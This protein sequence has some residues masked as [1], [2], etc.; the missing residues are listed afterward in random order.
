MPDLIRE[1]DYII[2]GA[3]SAG[4]VLANRLSA[5]P[6]NRVLVVEAGGPDRDPLIHIPL[7]IGRI[8]KAR[9]HD[10][11]Y[12]I[13][14][15][16]GLLGRELETMRG[17]VLGGSSSI[18]HMSHVRG[19]AGDYDRWANMGLDG[20]S[21]K[22]VLPYFRR[23]ESWG[24]G[25]DVYRGGDGPLTVTP[26]E[27]PD[28]LFDAFVR[29]AEDMGH[30]YTEDYN[31]ANQVG[32]GRG[33]TTIRKG[34]RH[35]AARAFLK[36]AMSRPNLTVETGAHV[37]KITMDGTR[38]VGIEYRHRGKSKTALGSA[39]I[40]LSGGVYNSPQ[41]L[42]LA[43]IGPKDHLKSHGIDPL[44][45]LPGV[46]ANLQ[47][48]LGVIVGATRPNPGPFLDDMRFDRMTVSMVR[49]FLLGT[50][51]ATS[52]PGG[53]HG[54]FKTKDGLDSPDIQLIFRAVSSDPHLWFPGIRKPYE[55]RCGIRPI[56]LH[57][58]SRGRVTLQSSD[59]FEK[60]HIV[61]NFFDDPDDIE[62][63]RRGVKLSREMLAN[64][65]LDDFRG[66]EVSPGLAVTQDEDI[67][68]WIR[69]RSSTAHHPSCTCAMGTGD[70]AV[71]DEHLR[72]RGAENLRVVDASAMPD[73][74]SGNIN[75][76]VLMIA[77]KASDHILGLEPL[78]PI[79]P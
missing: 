56:L 25:A 47:D 45:D 24:K 9:N 15:E 28:P 1:F 29:A 41:L 46:G 26:S 73:L 12:D 36:P 77:E 27:T 3:G 49:A 34:R 58:K 22:D 61:Q 10:W 35:S 7:G 19:N 78:A 44:I 33:Q 6:G 59:P 72:V 4:C 39:E 21:Y 75:A 2:V 68:Q 57:P 31:G 42:M 17:K 54:Y 63:L 43:G 69:K 62:T 38:A 50:G 71:L 64:K 55:D 52:L 51:P 16:P 30:A 66:V 67:D 37:T 32:V 5:D 8:H 70:M 23:T 40:I 79:T 74:V 11:G 60:V 18:N 14:P 20:W 48:H 76:C 53:L 65:A 13:A